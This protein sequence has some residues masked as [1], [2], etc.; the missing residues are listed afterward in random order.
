MIVGEE[1]H[2]ALK[3]AEKIGLKTVKGGHMIVN[4]TVLVVIFIMMIFSVYAMWDSNQIYRS[5]DAVHYDVYRPRQGETASFEE[6]QA[7]NP[8]VIAWLMVYG[9][10]IDYPVVQGEDN[11][12]YV[13]TDAFGEYSLS[14]AIFLDSRNGSD[15]TDFN[16]ILYGHHMDKDAMFGAIALFEDVDFFNEH[17]HG[18]LFYEGVDYGLEFFAFIEDIDAYDYSVFTPRVR[19]AEEQR[20]YLNNL[21]TKAIN[22]RDVGVTM[23]DRILLLSTCD[24]ALTNGRDILI[25]R[26]TD[27]T[28]A[29]PFDEERLPLAVDRLLELPVWVRLLAV[30]ILLII[31]I[32]LNRNKGKKNQK[33]KNNKQKPKNKDNKKN[34]KK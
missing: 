15:F 32:A 9:T 3:K 5:A 28:Y 26:I 10:S 13:T 30:V 34:K 16:S 8:E 17:T 24:S 23:E 21:I 27:E 2:M 1:V 33:N 25:A 12:K 14:G 29:N 20:N 22:T 31:I 11:R 7:E 18:N 6:F 19:D 4:M